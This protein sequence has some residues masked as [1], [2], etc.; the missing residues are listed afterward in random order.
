MQIVA[1]ESVDF[2][3]IA[4]FRSKGFD[5]YSITENHSGIND[6]DVL[7]IANNYNCLLVTEDKDFGELTYRLRHD[8]NCLK[9]HSIM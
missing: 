6:P 1:D 5:V 7:E 3:I 9:L 8:H 2:G 4:G